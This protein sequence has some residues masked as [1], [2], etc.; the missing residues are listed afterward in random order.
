MSTPYKPTP[1]DDVILDAD[2]KARLLSEGWNFGGRHNGGKS[3]YVT[4]Q[5]V[6]GPITETAFLARY[7]LN[8]SPGLLVDHINGNVR[9]NRIC[10]LRLATRAQNAMNKGKVEVRVRNGVKTRAYSKY[11]GVT[12]D[13]RDKLWQATCRGYIGRYDSEEMAAKAYDTKARR[14]FGEF[15]RLNFPDS[16]DI[17]EA[18]PRR[19]PNKS[20]FKNIK[21]GYKGRFCGRVAI[22]GK[23]Y[24]TASFDTPQEA[25]TALEELRASLFSPH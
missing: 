1:D 3:I 18:P 21:M 16:H 5:R 8:A 25:S 2:V 14:V 4:L 23:E 15:A 11:T 13:K 10:N 19:N 24:Y 22:N 7:L 12:F 9:D 17:V 20:G 6:R